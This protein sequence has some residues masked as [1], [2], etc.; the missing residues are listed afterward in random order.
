[1]ALTLERPAVVRTDRLVETRRAKPVKWWAVVGGFWVALQVYVFTAWIVSGKA[2]PT[3]R[4]S[5]PIPRWMEVTAGIWEVAG[6]FALAAFV[7]WFL[8]RPWRR[9][10]RFTL[11][12]MFVLASLLLYWQD[13]LFN[14][15]QNWAVYNTVFHNWGSWTSNIPGWMS[16]NGNLFAEPPIFTAPIYVYAVFGGVLV[17]NAVMRAAKRRWPNL[18]TLGMIGVA[19]AFVLVFE[20]VVEGAF[21]RL[22]FWGY[23]GSI[24]WL[25]LFHGHYYQFPIA[26]IVIWGSTWTGLACLRYFKNDKG[27]TLA[28]RGI[29]RVAGSPAQKSG[30]KLLALIGITNTLLFACYSI[31]IQFFA[32]HADPWP[33]DFVN[34]SYMLDG[35]C[36]PGTDYSCSGPGVPIPRPD[37]AH[38]DPDGQLAPG[39]GR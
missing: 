5:T 14:Y 4:G 19:L 9:E 21:L 12:G 8:V 22:G 30:L 23:P 35:L 39:G 33:Q 17:T 11:D 28:E 26:E 34:R 7:Y 27:Q 6:L 13:P 36:G 31:P 18:G 15:T 2:T 37:S 25:T 38:L 32:L 24:S 1:M 16:P 29:E 20:I 3:P 10:R